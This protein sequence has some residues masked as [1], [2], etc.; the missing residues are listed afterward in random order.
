MSHKK[1]IISFLTLLV[2]SL[3][4]IGGFNYYVDPYGI[5]KKFRERGF[6]YYKRDFYRNTRLYKVFNSIN[7]NPE[8]LFLGNSRTEYLA[9]EIEYGKASNKRCYN[10]SLSSGQAPEML[11]YLKFSLNHFN[12]KEVYYGADFGSFTNTSPPYHE[13]FDL[14]LVRGKKLI[15]AEKMKLYLT[16]KAL[17]SSF[18]CMEINENDPEGFSVKYQYN[19]SG[20]RTNRWREIMY[21]R[22]GNKWL[23][24]EFNRIL[25]QYLEIYNRDTLDFLNSKR[26]AYAAIH[27]LVQKERLKYT[28]YVTP[29]Y[30]E[31]FKL[32]LKSAN[33]DLYLEFLRF[34]SQNGGF[35][36]FGGINEIT[37]NPNYFWDSQHPRK[38]MSKEMFKH[39]KQRRMYTGDG[40]PWGTFVDESN[41]ELLE[42]YVKRL[43][44]SIP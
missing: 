40:D 12:I 15:W 37:S 20:S 2:F 4:M 31:Q 35:Y 10:F 16:I 6:N 42:I 32:I 7:V 21:Q 24:N 9:P 11:E 3:I 23:K 1:Y 5:N 22:N 36:F 43:K 14:D 39:F 27:E 17:E 34:I 19:E 44:E 18:K 13:T 25:K 8:V 38:S 33:F 26:G 41:V 30:S 29:L 28:P